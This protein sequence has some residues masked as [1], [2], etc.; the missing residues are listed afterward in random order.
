MPHLAHFDRGS[1]NLGQVVA[2]W[3][4]PL[5][6]WHPPNIVEEDGAFGLCIFPMKK[7][8]RVLFKAMT[9]F[10]IMVFETFFSCSSFEGSYGVSP[11]SPNI[12]SSFVVTP[13]N[14]SIFVKVFTTHNFQI[15]GLNLAINLLLWSTSC[16]LLLWNNL[17]RRSKYLWTLSLGF[18]LM[19]SSFIMMSSTSIS[20]YFFTIRFRNSIQSASAGC[21]FLNYSLTL[22]L[23]FIFTILKILFAFK[24]PTSITIVSLST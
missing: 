8:I 18:C 24:S 9:C 15:S 17:S 16:N 12:L 2:K 22:L 1:F 10:S 3:S 6:I 23:K 20:P 4:P 21:N 19:A 13:I 5:Q 7:L 14:F 11:S